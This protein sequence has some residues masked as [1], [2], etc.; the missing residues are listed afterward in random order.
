MEV[1]SLIIY[2][3]YFWDFDMWPLNRVWPLN[4]GRLNGG[5]TVIT[6]IKPMIVLIHIHYCQVS[7]G[8]YSY[9]HV[10]TGSSNRAN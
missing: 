5:S 10:R 7:Y 8:P 9:I 6:I 1:L 3:K 2:T 4:G